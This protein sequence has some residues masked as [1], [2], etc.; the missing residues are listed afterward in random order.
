[1][2]HPELDCAGEATELLDMMDH[3]RRCLYSMEG[4]AKSICID[5]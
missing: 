3:L 4:P 2:S 1:M 5:C